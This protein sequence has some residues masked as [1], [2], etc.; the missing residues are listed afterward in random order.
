MK[1]KLSP[2]AESQRKIINRLKRANGQ[3]TAVINAIESE[4]SC[5]EIVQQISAVS[6]AIDR[7]GFLVV[8]NALQEC[9]ANPD[10]DSEM[11]PEELEKLFLSLS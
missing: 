9:I 11:T 4:A 2:E 7:A 5:R 10:A 6:K 1:T 8:S 3:L